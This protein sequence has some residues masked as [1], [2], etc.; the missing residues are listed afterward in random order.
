MR[1]YRIQAERRNE[2]ATDRRDTMDRVKGKIPVVQ[3]I[4]LADRLIR[5]FGGNAILAWGALSLVMES[6]SPIWATVA[7]LIAVYPLMTTVM[8]WDPFYQLLGTRTCSVETGRNQCGTFP[9]EVDAALGHN[10]RPDK[11]YEYDHSLTGSHHESERR[12]TA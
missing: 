9:Y 5:F 7:I 2:M 12:A 6:G 4:G 1:T 10:P 3:N 8:G 11:G